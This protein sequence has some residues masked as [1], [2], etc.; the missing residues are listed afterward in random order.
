MSGQ[1]LETDHYALLPNSYSTYWESLYANS[2]YT[3]LLSCNFAPRK[4]FYMG[5]SITSG[6][7]RM[8]DWSKTQKRIFM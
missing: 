4:Y 1:C 6:T 5:R 3:I 7:C 2:I 8:G